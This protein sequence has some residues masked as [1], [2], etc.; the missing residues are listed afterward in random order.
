[1]FIIFSGEGLTM[2]HGS[3][4]WSFSHFSSP[5]HFKYKY[6]YSFWPLTLQFSLAYV[7]L[8]APFHLHFTWSV[9]PDLH[10]SDHFLI[11]FI[12]HS[13][14]RPPQNP[15]WQFEWGNWSLFPCQ[16]F[17]G[18]GSFP[19]SSD[20]LLQI[21]MTSVL[22]VTSNTVSQTS[23]R[24]SPKCMPWWTLAC[25]HAVHLKCAA[26]GH[27]GY[28]RTTEMLLNFYFN[29]EWAVAQWVICKAKWTCWWDYVSTITSTSSECNFDKSMDIEWQLLSRPS[30]SS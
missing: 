10:D 24:H 15:C 9:V 5:P 8:F 21:F 1:M 27:Y 20:E 22:T 30:S 23:G 18:E 16:I 28:N 4:F 14:S 19:L 29:W 12:S 11:I 2:T 6:S 25:A 3:Q 7:C 13:Y 17:F 26:W